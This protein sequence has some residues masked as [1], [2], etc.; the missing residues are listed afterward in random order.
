MQ[1]RTYLGAAAGLIGGGLAGCT[2]VLDDDGPEATVE[3]LFDAIADGDQ[4]A[5]DDLYHESGFPPTIGE[6]ET[7]FTLLDAE[8]R[9][10][11]ETFETVDGTAGDED[12]DQAVEEAEAD[13]DETVDEIGADGWTIVVAELEIEGEEEDAPYVLV[14]TDG[15]WLILE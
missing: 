3:A 2:D 10:V 15:E 6:E 5:V 8:E 9:S 12:I 11:R 1:R 14:E 7:Q 4:D 13:L